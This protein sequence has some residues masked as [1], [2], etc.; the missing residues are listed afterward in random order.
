MPA[1]AFV[2]RMLGL[3]SAGRTLLP[4]L[5][6]PPP[7]PGSVSVEQRLAA[8]PSH[9]VPLH[10]KVAI[11][12]NK[13]QVPFIEASSDDDLATAFGVVHVHLRWTQME[14]MRRVAQGRM[15]ELVGPP[16][17][18]ID[19]L[20]R[21][22]DFGR[23]VPAIAAALPPETRHWLNAHLAGV[24]HAVAQ[25]PLPPDF[26]AFGLTREPWTLPDL[27]TI[28][29]LAGADA[30]W[31]VWLS[32]LPL[33][34]DAS[35]SAL[36]RR[37]LDTSGAPDVAPSDAGAAVLAR[38]TREASNALAVSPARSQTGAA[39]MAGDTHLP[40]LLPN[41]WLLAGCRSPSM[42]AV[43]LMVP[44]VPGFLLGR[45]PHIAWG[46][47]NL[48]A[49]SSDVY[50]VTRVPA[51]KITTRNETLRVRG[52]RNRR[53]AIRETPY[54]PIISDLPNL[55]GGRA[56]A[57]RWI[58]HYPSDEITAL[59][60]MAR[61]RNWQEF[62]AALNLIAV[63]GQNMVFA[64]T[65]GHI[66]KA[67]AVHLPS[68]P[69]TPPDSLLL[70]TDAAAAWDQCV[71]GDALPVQYDP[72]EGFIAS[73]NE[74][75]PPA[76][77]RIGWFFSSGRRIGRLRQLL[78]ATPKI[79]FADLAALQQ[80]IEMPAAVPIL[81][82][83]LPLLRGHAPPHLVQTLQHW[84]LRY[85]ASSAGALAFEQL[86][87]HL[88]VALHGKRRA[89]IYSGTWNAR[90]SLFQDIL[91]GTDEAIGTAL[92]RA[93]PPTLRA[94]RRFGTWGQVHRQELRHFLGAVPVVGRRYRFGNV[95]AQG[96]NDTLLKSGNPLTGRRHRSSF[97]STARQICDLSDPDAT[98]FV[99]LGGQ[100]GWLGSTTLVDQ[101]ELYRRGDYIRMPLRPETVQ[102]E[103]PLRTE[104]SP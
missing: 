57:L 100:D 43:G 90:G 94:L 58:G 42:H 86:L 82:R 20:L 104:L 14:L 48:H 79:G 23:A 35:L 39:W 17:V 49:A 92:R 78:Q 25:A 9:G 76:P 55:R 21:M 1:G 41:L 80:D 47:T 69:D 65:A 18:A 4:H 7:R 61:A 81:E 11:H 31:R 53:I 51:Q 10:A 60:H 74:K 87:Y 75:P 91:N 33:R 46:G 30:T 2:D 6:T 36:W 101:A 72:P 66:G 68:R 29:R 16:G 37:L 63:P 24:N 13:H 71:T 54:G 97:A 84:D 59:L 40:A 62:R 50:D 96:G 52:A 32:L 93:V 27:L 88:C 38:F 19:H 103:F 12:W 8:L 5:L 45:T 22:L 56:V 73:A 28:A 3:A 64:D 26:P 67:L 15:A 99:L 85:D 34:E 98:W 83:L 95:A 44:G 70:P 102:A 77:V 89:A